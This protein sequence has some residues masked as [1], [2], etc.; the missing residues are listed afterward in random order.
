[1][2]HNGT[3]LRVD[4]I[5][6]HEK[7]IPPR[8]YH[9]IAIVRVRHGMPFSDEVSPVCLPRSNWVNKTKLIGKTA[10]VAGFGD[11]AFG[12]SQAMV[13]QQVDLKILNNTFCENNYNDLVES[14]SKFP[15]GMKGSLICA[16]HEEG[17]KDACQ[18]IYLRNNIVN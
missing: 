7:Y 14:R 6:V 13:L 2:I 10:F 16:G 1:M 4:R 5:Y 12:G 8:I 3:M 11:M 15:V 17:G 9:D 18:V